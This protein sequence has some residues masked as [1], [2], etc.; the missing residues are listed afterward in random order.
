MV[1]WKMNWVKYIGEGE[2]WEL[3]VLIELV[4]VYRKDYGRKLFF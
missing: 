2:W 1:G 3:L 4:V